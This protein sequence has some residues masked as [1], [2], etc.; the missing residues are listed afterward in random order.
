MA[1]LMAFGW[2]GTTRS[3]DELSKAYVFYKPAIDWVCERTKSHRKGEPVPVLVTVARGWYSLE[4]ER[5]GQFLEVFTSGVVARP[6]DSA[7]IRLRDLTRSNPVRAGQKGG[8]GGRF[9]IYRKANTAVRA[10]CS[11]Q[12]LSK[13]YAT[14]DEFEIPAIGLL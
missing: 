14:D 4:H 1:R 8:G 5:L 2:D 11:Y 9:E 3:F 10:F 6:S 7:A 13:L 12:P